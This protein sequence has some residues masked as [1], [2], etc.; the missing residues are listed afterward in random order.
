MKSEIINKNKLT[1]IQ[2]A[3]VWTLPEGEKFPDYS[4][5]DE[6]GSGLSRYSS[7]S[8]IFIESGKKSSELDFLKYSTIHDTGTSW[9][10]ADLYGPGIINKFGYDS[11]AYKDLESVILPELIDPE[12]IIDPYGVIE[13]PWETN[14]RFF[15]T[16]SMSGTSVSLLR[17]PENSWKIEFY[18]EREVTKNYGKYF[19]PS[20]YLAE[21]EVYPV[22][23]ITYGP[24]PDLKN[25]PNSMYESVPGE[26]DRTEEVTAGEYKNLIDEL[27]APKVLA[28][29][30]T[31][32]GIENI[33]TFNVSLSAWFAQKDQGENPE[34][35]KELY[36]LGNS[37]FM[38]TRDISVTEKCG[39]TLIDPLSGILLGSEK[40][41]KAPV[42]SLI[43]GETYK[44]PGYILS[45]PYSPHVRYKKGDKVIYGRK[46]YLSR[47]N[48][49]IGSNPILSK[50]WS[51]TNDIPTEG[52]YLKEKTYNEVTLTVLGGGDIVFPEKINDKNISLI[53]KKRTGQIGTS[54]DRNYITFKVIPEGGYTLSP[55]VYSYD[56]K[57]EESVLVAQKDGTYLLRFGYVNGI[58]CGNHFCLK[59]V[60]YRISVITEFVVPG[61]N[62]YT[63]IPELFRYSDYNA[64]YNSL[65]DQN[66]GDRLKIL[67]KCEGMPV[68]YCMSDGSEIPEVAFNSIE[69]VNLSFSPDY[70][71]VENNERIQLRYQGLLSKYDIQYWTNKEHDSSV[72]VIYY[73]NTEVSSVLHLSNDEEDA[74]KFGY[75]GKEGD[76]LL[77]EPI[78][79]ESIS[80]IE[81]SLIPKKIAVLINSIT[82]AEVSKD[83]VYINI[84][85][86]FTFEVFSESEPH[87][88]TGG[89]QCTYEITRIST[90][91]WSVEVF[92]VTE[93]G[94][95][96]II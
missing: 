94:T 61:V 9:N 35:H 72:S 30:F 75:I 66:S 63:Y 41:E 4:N 36:Y 45:K 7:P 38:D 96:L 1:N 76:T 31:S 34:R 55:G 12:T 33:D 10:P 51:L 27:R 62:Y 95:I 87:I 25:N 92:G 71:I 81:I 8:Y 20:E 50:A 64:K 79:K 74:V 86:S 65:A 22:L 89:L 46:I 52:F 44:Q 70:N 39:E 28:I 78:I 57:K 5:L 43:F 77:V 21:L 56:T 84:G 15:G 17:L 69:G 90:K 16:V 23:R 85:E 11:E 24:S 40:L 80:K 53:G 19:I 48:N 91:T 42:R 82:D 93:S 14:V 54:K 26:N 83:G 6:V 68:Y 32:S 60:K 59:F 88:D 49:N 58:Y 47:I 2:M 18:S 3:V 73:K 67:P 37:E 13:E 29:K